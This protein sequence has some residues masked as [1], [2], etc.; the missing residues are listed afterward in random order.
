MRALP[1]IAALVHRYLTPC[2][3]RLFG[4]RLDSPVSDDVFAPVELTPY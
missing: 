1:L 4:L 3:P 2:V